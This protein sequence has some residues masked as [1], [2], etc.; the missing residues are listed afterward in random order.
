LDSKEAGEDLG[1]KPSI[2]IVEGI[3]RTVQW[4]RGSLGSVPAALVDA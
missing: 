4:L 3:Q 2:N 1:W